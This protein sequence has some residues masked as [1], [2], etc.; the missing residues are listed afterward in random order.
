MLG[1]VT[2]LKCSCGPSNVDVDVDVDADAD[3]D[4]LKMIIIINETIR[5]GR[6]KERPGQIDGGIKITH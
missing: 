4:D 5:E 1:E 2:R 3:A 6:K